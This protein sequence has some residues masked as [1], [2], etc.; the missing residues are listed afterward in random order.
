MMALHLCLDCRQLVR[1]PELCAPC[2]RARENARSARR[3]PSGWARQRA[4]A[5][6]IA[7]EGGRCVICGAPATEVD[8][9]RPLA[10]GGADTEENR[11]PLCNGCHVQ[12]GVGQNFNG[13]QPPHAPPRR[14][15][16]CT[17]LTLAGGM[18]TWPE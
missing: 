4:N 15:G 18:R 5:A 7:R 14:K 8:H 11:R 9:V 6:T 10:L 17:G 1:G 2:R 3:G 16:L 13:R 12:A